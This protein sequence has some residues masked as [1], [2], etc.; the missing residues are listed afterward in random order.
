MKTQK[1]PWYVVERSEALAHILLTSRPDVRIR[2]ETKTDFG[3]NLLV[4][5]GAGPD[6]SS[7]LFVVQIK[8]TTSSDPK[9]WLEDVK[10]LFRAGESSM[11]WPTCVFV[12]DVRNNRS[13]YAWIAEPTIEPK[14]VSIQ[15]RRPSHFHNLD[16]AAVDSIVD[17]VKAWYEAFPDTRTPSRTQTEVTRM[18]PTAP[19]SSPSS[20]TLSFSP[21]QP[22]PTP[23][24]ATSS[25]PPFAA[26][27]MR[28]WKGRLRKADADPDLVRRQ[29]ANS[30]PSLR[31]CRLGERSPP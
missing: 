28:E 20:S 12:L 23:S 30:F 8:G 7:R 24:S 1:A 10:E 5:V 22:R 29:S 18:S 17:Q 4:E 9:D 26:A 21:N 27:T 31:A 3:M 14:S 2:T 13:F 25:P 6:L 16:P 11:F 19:G 15:L